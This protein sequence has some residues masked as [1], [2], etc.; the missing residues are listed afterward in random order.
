[1]TE[2]SS[3]TKRHSKIW[4]TITRDMNKINQIAVTGTQCQSKMNGLKKTYKKVLDHNN[5]SGNNRKSWPYFEVN[6]NVQYIFIFIIC[7]FV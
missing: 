5:I 1:M 2:F 3:G 6:Y 7:I 4:D